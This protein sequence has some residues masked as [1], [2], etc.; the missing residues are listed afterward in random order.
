[1]PSMRMYTHRAGQ[2]GKLHSMT[3]EMKKL[4]REMYQFGMRVA[5]LEACVVHVQKQE[6]HEDIIPDMLRGAC[7]Y[8]LFYATLSDAIDIEIDRLFGDLKPLQATLLD[9]WGSEAVEQASESID[10]KLRRKWG[11]GS[12]RF[13][14]GYSGFN[15]L[16]NKEWLNVISQ[17][18]PDV[19][20]S[21]SEKT[22]IIS[23]RKSVLCMIGWGKTHPLARCK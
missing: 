19:A 4:L 11:I 5:H 16:K 17:I 18:K 9:A 10:H 14:P 2:I 23:P 12:I 8:S 21:V 3:P 1:M 15:V 13:S 6:I 20:I 7:S 22:G